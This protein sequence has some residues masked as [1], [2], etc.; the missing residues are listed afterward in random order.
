M[1]N[2][3]ELL[4]S[5]YGG[6]YSA[7]DRLTADGSYIINSGIY[8]CAEFGVPQKRIRSLI[9]GTKRPFA[10]FQPI[11]HPEDFMTVRQ[12]IGDL[13]AVTPGEHISSDPMHR[14]AKHK[15]STVDVIK[16]VAADGGSRPIGVGPACLDRVKGFY[17]VYGRLAW[18]KPS[19]TITRYARNPASGRFVH[20]E[21]DRGLTMR[22]AARLQSFP[23][24]FEFDD[25]LD[26]VFL[27]IGEAVPPLFS[28]SIA[29]SVR[30]YF[31][32]ETHG[33][34]QDTSPEHA[35]RRFSVEAENI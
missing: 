27:Q 8:N 20:P 2:V 12:A 24:Q 4:S 6:Y 26:Q 9:V 25:T 35:G 19:I 31:H 11:I 15:Q 32:L 16:A 23:D 13:P 7:F 29:N 33:Q 10:G 3:P 14:S 17:D 18:D 1:E 34:T 21:Q 5:R 30:G 22:E 28:T